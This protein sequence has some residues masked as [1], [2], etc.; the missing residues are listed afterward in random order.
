MLC[1]GQGNISVTANIAPKLLHELCV[2]AVAGDIKTAMAIQFKLLSLHKAMGIEGNPIAVKWAM[3]RLG[4]CGPA[5]RLPLTELTASGQTAVEVA[6]RE[7][8]LLN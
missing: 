4:L 8:G 1:G 7:A 2:A 3:K 5:I 6:M